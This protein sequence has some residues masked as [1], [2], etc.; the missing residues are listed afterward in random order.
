VTLLVGLLVLGWRDRARVDLSDQLAALLSMFT[1][2][3]FG[4]MWDLIEF[5]LDWVGFTDLQTSNSQTMT[6]LLWNDVGAVV[7]AVVA[8]R[9]YCHAVSPRRREELGRVAA[10]LV[11]GPGGVLNRHGLLVTLVVAVGAM[12]TVVSLWFAGRPMPGFPN[13]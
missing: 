11:D 9:L 10:W 1:G 2:M 4:V 13:G 8:T 3:L 7:G 12:L 5:V 6:D